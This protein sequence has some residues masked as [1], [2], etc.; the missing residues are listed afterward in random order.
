VRPDEIVGAEHASP[1]QKRREEDEIEG[2]EGEKAEA[3]QREE[4][5]GVSYQLSAR[6]NSQLSA[7]G[8]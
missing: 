6:R 7:V 2:Q 3:F 1:H 5:S 4:L 8:S